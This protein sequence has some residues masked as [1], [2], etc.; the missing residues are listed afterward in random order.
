[1]RSLA[2]LSVP[3]PAAPALAT[4][5]AVSW[6][7][8]LASRFGFLGHPATGGAVSA[9]IVVFGCRAASRGDQERIG[10][11][12]LIQAL[13]PAYFVSVALLSLFFFVEPFRRGRSSG[14]VRAVQ[15]AGLVLLLHGAPS[16]LETEPG[17][18]R[19]G[20]MPAS[21]DRSLTSLFGRGDVGFCLL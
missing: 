8:R 19:R 15:V 12:G 10:N 13:P 2:E 20:C 18:P 1:M 6:P 17:S 7:R 9:A 16:L 11:W 4:R 14:L 21:P 3:E 5:D